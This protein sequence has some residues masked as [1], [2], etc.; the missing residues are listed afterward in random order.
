MNSYPSFDQWFAQLCDEVK[1]APS[2]T[3]Q[4][5]PFNNPNARYALVSWQAVD[6]TQLHGR[7]IRPNT[8]QQVPL[9][10][11]FHDAFVPVRGWHHMTRFVAA[12]FAV[13][14]L[15]N[16][17]GWTDITAGWEAGPE[18]LLPAVFLQDAVSA[19]AI[20]ASFPW[21]SDIL[22]WGEGLGGGMAIVTAAVCPERI[23]R[24]A[25]A[26]PM[27]AAIDIM[28]DKDAAS[29][30]YDG[31]TRYFRWK[32]PERRNKDAL[33]SA[34]SLVDTVRFAQHLKGSVLLGTGGMD[35]V[36]PPETQE[37]L[38]NAISC[39]K[40]RKLY[41]KHAH[42]RINDFEDELL[43]FMRPMVKEG[44]GS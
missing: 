26:N 14:A 41:A 1:Q 2:Y 40:N 9:V 15:E 8:D 29:P 35:T 22:A 28:L 34:L 12:G 44:E 39:E 13:L 21:V 10:L 4:T 37:R 3:A 24:C 23:V 7:L 33:C 31:I 20:A 36:S 6:G 11:M 5:A 16:R 25:A 27:P 19:A 43:R 32:D 38:W 17:S 30:F 42:E 18:H